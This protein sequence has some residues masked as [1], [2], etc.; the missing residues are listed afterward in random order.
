MQFPLKEAYRGRLGPLWGLQSRRRRVAKPLV[1]S[2]PPSGK[3]RPESRTSQR[4]SG[5]RPTS[6]NGR[7]N[8]KTSSSVRPGD[9]PPGLWGSRERTNPVRSGLVGGLGVGG[10]THSSPVGTTPYR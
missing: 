4:D 2:S 7:V 5:R 3:V 6:P 9:V 8:G 1:T 10:W